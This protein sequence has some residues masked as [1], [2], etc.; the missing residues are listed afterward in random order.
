MKKSVTLLSWSL[1]AG[2]VYFFLV[3]IA[4]FFQFK[5]PMLFIY[6]NL[7]SYVY[8]DQIIAFLSFGWGMFLFAG[9]RS[10]KVNEL[11]IMNYI[12]IA[13]VGAII[14]LTVINS[15]IDFQQFNKSIITL[16]FWT[17]A[18]ILILYVVLLGG[19]YYFARKKKIE[20]VKASEK[21][22]YLNQINK[23]QIEL[24]KHYK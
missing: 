24:I 20:K 22:E 10:V 13:G 5:I 18:L 1:L 6:F 15:T 9:F 3:T 21:Y 12:L 14:G 19:L 7:P 8:Q 23:E 16:Y 4:H 2:A 11:V 17:E